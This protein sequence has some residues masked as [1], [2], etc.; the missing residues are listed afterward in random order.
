MKEQISIEFVLGR[1][2][3]DGP[4][5]KPLSYYLDVKP[6][7]FGPA[8]NG[9]T[10]KLRELGVLDEKGKEVKPFTREVVEAFGINHFILNEEVE[11]KIKRDF[12]VITETITK[13]K[14]FRGMGQEEMKEIVKDPASAMRGALMNKPADKIVWVA[15]VLTRQRLKEPTVEMWFLTSFFFNKLAHAKTLNFLGK[16]IERLRHLQGM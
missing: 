4:Q 9:M 2:K 8:A 10:L 16:G 3:E 13:G 14:G 6:E 15:R 12:G 1:F 5:D 11:N 7:D